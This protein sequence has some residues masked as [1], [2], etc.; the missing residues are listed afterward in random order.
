MPRLSRITMAALS[1]VL[2]SLSMPPPANAA[3]VLVQAPCTYTNGYCLIFSAGV[4]PIPV[5]RSY[6]FVMPAKGA[7]LVNFQGTLHCATDGST[8]KVIDIV[9]QIVK[10]PT[11]VPDYTKPGGS[12]NAL[13]L[14]TTDGRFFLP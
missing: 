2:F 8:P 4:T 11:D 12:R 13:A 9:S 1:A 5:V 14:T 3:K 6:T 7:A 10:L